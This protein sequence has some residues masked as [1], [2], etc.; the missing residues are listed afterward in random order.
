MSWVHRQLKC[1]LFQCIATFFQ[2]FI[3]RKCCFRATR[4]LILWIGD[5]SCNIVLS[6]CLTSKRKIRDDILD[7]WP[8]LSKI[9]FSLSTSLKIHLSN[10]VW[11][12]I[13]IDV[14][15]TWF[16]EIVQFS[17]SIVNANLKQLLWFLK[18]MS[19]VELLLL[20]KVKQ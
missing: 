8:K 14:A 2:L 7:H 18:S 20:L 11:R 5:R 17:V 6:C 12:V 4:K 16:R 9:C 19:N 15:M 3:Y 13:W 1:I 10:V